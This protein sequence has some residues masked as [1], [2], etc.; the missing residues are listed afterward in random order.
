MSEI[1]DRFID[2]S[3]RKLNLLSSRIDD[4]LSRL[5][6]DQVWLRDAENLNAVGNLVLH[7]CGN[8]RQ[9]VISGIGGAPDIRRRDEEFA[10]RGGVS[11]DELRKKV[12]DTVR[13][14]SSI[15]ERISAERLLEQ[16]TVQKYT[17]TVLEAVYTVIEH[18][19]QHTGQI[20]FATKLLTG[21]DLGYYAHLSK[22]SHSER[23]P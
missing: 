19:A 11:R 21:E 15:L 3:V 4:C 8:V 20:I 7:L 12:Q 13:E 14:A 22:P 1:R 10:A 2:F 16:L 5:D 18:F 17:L 9:W 6:D 23:T